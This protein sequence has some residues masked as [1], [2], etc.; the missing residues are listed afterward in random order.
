[1]ENITLHDV[2][3][4]IEEALQDFYREDSILLDYK[5]EDAAISERCITFHI[6]WYLLKHLQQNE[7]TRKFVVDAE[8][9]RCF[10]HP[11][12]MY[13]TTEE[14][15]RQKIGDTYPDLIVHKRRS[16]ESNLVIIEFKKHGN[17]E[18]SGRDD[19]FKK[20][21]YF[22]NQQNEYKFKYGFWIVLY[23]N[24]KANIHI[25]E[26]GIEKSAQ[27]YTWTCGDKNEI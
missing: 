6:G 4:L 17:Y 15:I 20:L 23:K 12:S 19:D 14:G 25:F 3:A 16:N 18:K 9:N 10:D 13:K 11:K 24:K 5:T 26:N 21:K 22:T 7:N 1:M 2:N 8:Y 27:K